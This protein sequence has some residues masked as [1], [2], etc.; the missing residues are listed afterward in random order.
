MLHHVIHIRCRSQATASSQVHGFK[1]SG[2]AVMT[3]RMPEEEEMCNAHTS[4][5]RFCLTGQDKAFQQ[6]IN[7]RVLLTD[8]PPLS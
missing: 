7:S 8:L 4:G 2:H 6:N 1:S 3:M 5:I